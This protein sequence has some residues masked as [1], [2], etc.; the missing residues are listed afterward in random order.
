M[1]LYYNKAEFPHTH[2]HPQ[3]AEGE[4]CQV[5]EEVAPLK[6]QLFEL[7]ERLRPSSTKPHPQPQSDVCFLQY[8]HVAR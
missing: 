1:T 5:R 3:M 8:L 7:Q 2:V 4:L 6:D